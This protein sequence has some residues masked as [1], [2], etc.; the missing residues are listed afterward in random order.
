MLA[1]VNRFSH[2]PHPVFH[3]FLSWTYL[4]M[5]KRPA[6]TR[7]FPCVTL[8]PTIPPRSSHSR[9]STSP[10]S[11]LPASPHNNGEQWTQSP[12]TL[13]LPLNILYLILPIYF[14]RVEAECW[15]RKLGTRMPSLRQLPCASRG[16][17]QPPSSMCSPLA[18]SRSCED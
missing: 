16:T 1:A 14:G 11:P 5:K 8:A 18:D 4:L 13:L 12:T 15:R 2:I 9:N 7:A 3:K 17:A 10:S 6:A